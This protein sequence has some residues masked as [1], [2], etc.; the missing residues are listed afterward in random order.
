MKTGSKYHPLFDY[1]QN[2][3]R[4]EITLSFSEIEALIGSLPATAFKK[5][6]WWSN[7]DSSSALQAKA[8]IGAS[9]SIESVD[10]NQWTV[11][12]RK[13][14]ASYNIQKTAGAITWRQDAIKALRKH[15]N[16]TQSKFAEKIGVRRQTVSEWENGVYDPDR[17]TA[18]FL[19]IIAEQSDFQESLSGK[20]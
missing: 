3:D 8:W 7:R 9:Y 18:K 2:C 15:L 6:N 13:F 1:L 17:S 14:Q 19:E 16:L 12:F 20:W 10:L 5:K 4:E 11:G